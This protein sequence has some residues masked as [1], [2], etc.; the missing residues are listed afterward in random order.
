[1]PSLV[2][3][4]L[5]FDFD[6]T[7]VAQ[8]Y[9][10]WQHWASKPGKKKVDVVAFEPVSK[11][12]T[13]WL[14]E[15]KDFRVIT[16]PPKSSNI[17]SLP[18]TVAQKMDDSLEGLKDAAVCASFAEKRHAVAAIATAERRVV[19][20]L[21]PYSPTGIHTALF[22][23]NF[24]VNVYQSLKRLVVH[25]DKNPLVLDIAKTPHAGVPWTVSNHP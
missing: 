18:Q 2:V 17:G 3:D 21:E 14:I 10:K 13:T 7:V 9:D 15:A 23:K 8:L 16:S 24:A 5:V 12:T 11:P 19:L 6:N 20:H 25:I 4:N 22:P 1:M